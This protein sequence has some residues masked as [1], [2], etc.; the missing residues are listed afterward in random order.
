MKSTFLYLKDFYTKILKDHPIELTLDKIDTDDLS[1][2]GQVKMI[3]HI[4]QYFDKFTIDIIHALNKKQEHDDYQ[5]NHDKFI[6][7]LMKQDTSLG[8][9][10][11]MGTY[12]MFVPEIS[13]NF[14][15]Q[16][17]N[18]RCGIS[19]NKEG[20]KLYNDLVKKIKT[21]KD[22]HD[23]HMLAYTKYYRRG[24]DKDKGEIKL[25]T[26]TSGGSFIL[27]QWALPH[28]FPLISPS[29]KPLE[30]LCTDG[31]DLEAM[32]ETYSVYSSMGWDLPDIIKPSDHYVSYD[33]HTS[34]CKYDT[35]HKSWKDRGWCNWMGK[36][37]DYEDTIPCTGA[38]CDKSK[39]HTCG[40]SSTTDDVLSFLFSKTLVGGAQ[41]ELGSIKA[42]VKNK[43]KQACKELQESL[44][45][46]GVH[47]K[48]VQRFIK[49]EKQA[50]KDVNKWQKQA[51]KDVK[52]EHKQKVSSVHH[53]LKTTFGDW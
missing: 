43:D 46:P 53:W 23:I 10:D 7:D 41:R 32:K 33:E 28:E 16:E 1:D 42:C 22:E 14:K 2:S 3:N 4:T 20:V 19:L 48:D 40:D 34:L 36:G 6:W 38:G 24:S 17:S 30:I 25:D 9:K 49:W 11:N 37:G 29:R 31:P 18:H 35:Q 45:P 15:D 13:K 5:L 52:K 8:I 50:E 51:V 47:V 26:K 39:Y 27:E 21:K 44:L 12:V